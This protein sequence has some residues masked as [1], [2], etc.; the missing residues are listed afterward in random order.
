MFPEKL[1]M[2]IHQRYFNSIG[3]LAR[4]YNAENSYISSKNGCNNILLSFLFT[5]LIF[6]VVKFQDTTAFRQ[7]NN[8]FGDAKI[9]IYKTAK[10]DNFTLKF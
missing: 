4:P 2:P 8:L 10:V 5:L 9:C 6:F 7:K 3:Q 1:I